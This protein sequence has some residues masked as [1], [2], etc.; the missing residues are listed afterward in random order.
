MI[1]EHWMQRIDALTRANE[2]EEFREP[3]KKIIT[4]LMSLLV[5][6]SLARGIAGAAAKPF[7]FDELLTLA[8]AGQP[9]SHA[10]WSAI[11]RGF[12]GQTPLFDL[13]ERACLLL[14][15]RQEISFRLPSILSFPVLLICVFAF[16]RKNL[17]D[18]IAF[19]CAFAMLSTSFFHVYLIEARG[20][21]VANACLAFA[22]VCYQ[23]SASFRWAAML[24][25]GLFLAQSFHHYAVFAMIPFG[26]AELVFFLK[27][28]LI[29]WQVWIALAVGMLPLFVSWPLLTRMK[30]YYGPSLFSRPSSF[31]IWT[32]YYG[33]YFFVNHG[34]GF[35]LAAVSV[36]A[37]ILSLWLPS[38]ASSHEPRTPLPAAAW[39]QGALLLG[40]ILLPLILF[41]FALVMHGGL[42]DRY[43]LAA[44]LGIVLAMASAL[45]VLGS[46]SVVLFALFLTASTF[47]NEKHFWHSQRVDPLAQ[48]AGPPPRDHEYSLSSVELDKVKTFLQSAESSNLPVVYA[49]AMAYPQ[50][51]HYS[52]PAAMRRLVCLVSQGKELEYEHTDNMFFNLT[53]LSEFY[54]L[55]LADY[56][57]FLSTNPE[58][59]VY[60][61]R[62][63]WPLHYLRGDI[64]S[65]QV[66]QMNGDM[67]LY[68]VK[69]KRASVD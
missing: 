25:L 42:L 31:F 27:T 2:R 69:M 64:G 3:L 59:L 57:E 40:V 11:A 30:A 15:L 21:M 4:A 47:I 24:G 16:V 45:A 32:Q 23:H 43:A 63:E 58:F 14:P 62:W 46:R 17:G 54:P 35:A 44:T 52:S 49:D 18:F 36:G 13:L 7:W 65:I 19:L 28:R 10:M 6:Y 5:L 51:V 68:F 1:P 48:E 33:S 50:V 60:A 55:R 12:D 41:T 37:I 66:L 67:R 34:L 8:I 61:D 22:L 38:R 9:T 20:Y 39:A 26:L 56:D 29:R 53:G